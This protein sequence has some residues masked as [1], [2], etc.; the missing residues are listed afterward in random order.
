MNIKDIF[1]KDLTLNWDVINDIPE[2]KALKGCHQHTQWHQEGDAYVHTEMVTKEID[3]IIKYSYIE[4]DRDIILLRAAALLHDIGKPAATKWDD[5]EQQW[6]T[7]DH[8]KAGENIV[9]R[10]FFNDD[11]INLRE[12]ICYMVR[13]HM[14]L[15]YIKDESEKSKKRLIKLSYGPVN[16]Y[17]M[18]LLNMADTKGSRSVFKTEERF[19][20]HCEL[21]EKLLRELDCV[22]E[23]YK[24]DSRIDK[25]CELNKININKHD[26][27]NGKESTIYIMCGIP[28]S[29]K[30]T[31]I[32]DKLGD[33]NIVSRDIIRYQLGY[34]SSPDEKIIG[35]KE[36]EKRVTEVSDEM[37]IK[38]CEENVDFVI[39]NMN[40]KYD[41]RRYIL[42]KVIKYNK[43]IVIIYVEPP[44]IYDAITCRN[45]YISPENYDKII[46]GMM[47]PM[48][49]EAD[50]VILYKRK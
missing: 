4:K 19:T 9:R 31:Y 32:K 30:S 33:I 23:P 8:G 29:G 46:D 27:I 11:D 49:Y 38:F 28:G 34:S 14:A 45:Q 21:I 25:L 17:L 18:Y 35:S 42:E 47:F 1:N 3:D 48:P 15:H 40:I 22:Y 43:R 13:N 37:M 16:L 36:Q 2:I 24:F 10:L 20:E 50:E 5:K 41:Y 26:V 39:D 44:T 7:H 12:Q 6:I